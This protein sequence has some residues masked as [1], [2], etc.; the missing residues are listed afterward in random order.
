MATTTFPFR[1][2][3]ATLLL[4]TPLFA[5][6]TRKADERLQDS[7]DFLNEIMSAPDRSIPQDLLN[8]AYCVVV[9]PGLKKGALIFGAKYGKG[10]AVCRAPEQGWGPP[11]AV[12]IEG[13]T[14]GFQAGF[15]S[16][17]VVLLVMNESGMKHLMKSKFTIGT[18]AT[19]AIGPVGRNVT[20]Q[21]DAMMRAEILSWSRSHGVFAGV[22]VD[23]ATLR[24]DTDENETLYN[25][26]W[27]SKE[28]LTSGATPP[29]AAKPL[30]DTLT[31]F[32]MRRTH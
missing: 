30:L 9:I 10:Y 8:K 25:K 21:T 6:D 31:K 13:G 29:A 3:L 20:A 5:D 15:S 14:A 23:G 12:R 19:A 28:I 4:M 11:A 2:L 27:T 17:D 7:A 32:S 16:S 24:G 18:D 22:S 26:R 1:P